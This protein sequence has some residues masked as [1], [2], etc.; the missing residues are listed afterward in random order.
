MIG[1]FLGLVA[2]GFLMTAIPRFT[3]AHQA[4]P[5][6]KIVVF[7]LGCALLITSFL[8]QRFWFDGILLII[9]LHMIRFGWSR[10]KQAHFMPL[11]P[12]VLVGFGIGAMLVSTVLR[13]LIQGDMVL[14]EDWVRLSSGIG[15]FGGGRRCLVI[16]DVPCGWL[17]G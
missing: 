12:F 7:V 3:G 17:H 5:W 14:G 8:P 6:E 4:S 13:L 16:S 9:F 2:V 1:G 11:P 15:R 10:L